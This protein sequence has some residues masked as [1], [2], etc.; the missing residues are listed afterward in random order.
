MRWHEA[1]LVPLASAFTIG[2]A[3]SAWIIAPAWWLLCAGGL[4]LGLTVLALALRLAP[5]ATSGLVALAMLLGAAR[6]VSDPL[7]PDHIARVAFGPAVSVEGRLV[8]DPVRW[9]PDRTRLLLDLDGL[10]DGI[11]RASCRERV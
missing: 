10:R 4:L 3:T 11:G 9:T 8:E 1:P 7:P 2:I 6:G 5:L